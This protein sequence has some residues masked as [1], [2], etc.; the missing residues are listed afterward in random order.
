M[1]DNE[2]LDS[3]L[4]VLQDTGPI[5]VATAKAGYQFRLALP[6]GITKRFL[7]IR[8]ENLTNDLTAGAVTATLLIDGQTSPGS[9][10]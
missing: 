9:M 3:N 6:V 1:A 5:A 2:A 7:G 4:V 8:Y 10:S